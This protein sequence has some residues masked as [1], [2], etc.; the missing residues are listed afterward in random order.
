MAKALGVMG[1]VAGL[2]LNAAG[3]EEKKVQIALT[4][5]FLIG[6]SVAGTGGIGGFGMRAVL[7]LKGPFAVSPEIDMYQY[8]R[9][10]VPACT[11][12]LRFGKGY[13]GLGPMVSWAVPDGYAVG[14]VKAHA[15]IKSRHWLI[16]ADY[17]AGGASRHT[18]GERTTLIGLTAGLVF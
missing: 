12:N 9:S 10:I 14:L 8:W 4:G 18:G 1:I 3:A 17:I 15:G 2:A 11:L 7:E 6:E 16:E 5:S 13:I